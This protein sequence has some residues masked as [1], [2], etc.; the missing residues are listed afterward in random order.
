MQFLAS[1]E[2]GF[3]LTIDDIIESNIF[4]EY[5]IKYA[6]ALDDEVITNKPKS[7]PCVVHI[8]EYA[9]DSID[10][11]YASISINFIYM[12]NLLD[13]YTFRK[14]LKELKEL[15]LSLAYLLED[16]NTSGTID[17][18]IVEYEA[19]NK[20]ITELEELLF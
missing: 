10:H 3:L 20:R 4:N 18:P 19:T 15:D 13:T 2:E 6:V 12:D 1:S 9:G 8:K 11:R 7:Y 16:I 5:A 17:K 14:N